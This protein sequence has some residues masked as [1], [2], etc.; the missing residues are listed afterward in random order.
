MR[1]IQ[2]YD[3]VKD[4]ENH[5][6][7][8]RLLECEYFKKYRS[9]ELNHWRN[10]HTLLN[11]LAE[12]HD[13]NEQHANSF[14]KRFRENATDFKNCEAIFAEVIVYHHYIRAVHEKLVRKIYLRKSEADIIVER[15]DR[16]EFFLEV[17]SLNPDFPTEAGQ[18]YDIKTHT[19]DALGS[20]RQKLLHKIK[21]QN[22]LCAPREN[23]A[24]IELNNTTIANDFSVLSSMSGGFK[25]QVDKNTLR[26]ISSGY[27][28]ESSVF[29]DP[30]TKFLTGIIWFK[31]GNYSLRKYLFN[32][33]GGIAGPARSRQGLGRP[34]D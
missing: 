7:L 20:I 22:Q 18:A 27:D 23:Y 1:S 19:Q 21:K 29:D 13:Y 31:L 32:P 17:F 15:S 25:V 24:V 33:N 10:Y 26:P 4:A 12:I 3:S 2:F 16:S 14:A 9:L 8:R 34:A 30:A 6:P 11:S 28:W 5:F